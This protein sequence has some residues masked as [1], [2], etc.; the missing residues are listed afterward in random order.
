VLSAPGEEMTVKISGSQDGR[1]DFAPKVSADFT[2]KTHEKLTIQGKVEAFNGAVITKSAILISTNADFTENVVRKDVEMDS[3]GTFTATFEGLTP[4]T[5]YY[6]MTYIDSD[7][8]GALVTKDVST[9]SAPKEKNYIKIS[10]YRG[11]SEPDYP[12]DVKVNFGSALVVNSAVMNKPGYTFVGW[13]Y[14]AALTQPYDINTVIEKG[15]E[16]FSLYAKWSKN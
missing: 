15:T 11:L 3:N 5:K 12:F 9:S 8:G 4:E 10:L 2:D 1:K 13:Y 16:P 14:D 7:H 6:Y